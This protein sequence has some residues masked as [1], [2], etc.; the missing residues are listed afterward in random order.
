MAMVALPLLVASC[1][2]VAV[3]VAEVAP[4]DGV[5][6]PLGALADQVTLFTNAPVPVT[7]AEHADGDGKVTVC[8]RQD[9]LTDVMVEA[10]GVTGRGSPLARTHPVPD[11]LHHSPLALPW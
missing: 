10:G 8:G 2:L 5:K 7:E 1:T 3:T 9:T 6:T 11:Q 4:L